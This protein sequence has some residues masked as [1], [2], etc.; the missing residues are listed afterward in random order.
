MRFCHA[1]HVGFGHGRKKPSKERRPC[2]FVGI[3][4]APRSRAC[5]AGPL[6]EEAKAVSTPET[7]TSLRSAVNDQ[8]VAKSRRTDSSA[9]RPRVLVLSPDYPPVIGGIET[10]AF[11]LVS[12]WSRV[13]SRVLTRS[14]PGS[15]EFDSEHPAE[16]RRT[17]CWPQ[18]LGN[19]FSLLWLNGA[20]LAQA[21]RFRPDVILSLHIV[22][23]P[24]AW[25]AKR[26][27]G[28]P[29]VQ[30]GHGKEIAARPRLA[31]FAFDNAAAG[32]VVST[33][34]ERLVSA[35]GA[36]EVALHRIPPGVRLPPADAER[37]SPAE[38]APVVLT[39]SRLDDGHKGH[40]VMVKAIEVVR[41]RVPDVLWVVIG[42]G[43]LKPAYEQMVRDGGLDGSVLFCGTLS[44][45]ERDEWLDRATV[46][47]MPSRVPAGGGGEGFGIAYLEAAARGVPAVAGNCGG[48]VDAVEDGKTGVLV[49]PSDHLAVA[50]A[51]TQLL[52]DPARTNALGASA[53]N[54]AQRFAWPR[55]AQEVEDLLIETSE[56]A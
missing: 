5:T 32:I 54:R 30:Y 31:R 25:A 36:N 9:P 4:W 33:H 51:I 41:A 47:A 34:T 10:L 14:G 2:R 27:L 23:S 19:R 26:L 40:D 21:L 22:T 6:Y 49:D 12:S 38:G 24:A 48:A 44:D 18:Q 46:F 3:R 35:C 37:D 1:H 29:H 7:T 15:R 16:V 8:L 39:V 42:D 20:A 53:A 11:G 17:A 28:I 52:R 43:A 13:Q 55:V 50:E 56:R 45:A